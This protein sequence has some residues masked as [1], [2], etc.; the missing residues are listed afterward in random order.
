MPSRLR[1][2][3]RPGGDADDDRSALDIPG[4][5]RPRSGDRIRAD[6][7][8]RN[9]NAIASDERVVFDCRLVFARSVVVRGDRASADI[10]S[11]P[12]YGIAEVG[13]VPAL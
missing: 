13:K 1:P 10:H 5:D 12:D 6:V 11:L 8:G 7:E 3:E 9:Q 4:D 2:P